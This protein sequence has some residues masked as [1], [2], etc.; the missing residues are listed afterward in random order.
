MIKDIDV[1]FREV[2]S[3]FREVFISVL[4]PAVVEQVVAGASTIPSPVLTELS[5]LMSWLVST[6]NETNV[7]ALFNS[8]NRDK[9]LDVLH[10]NAHISE[11]M[12]AAAFKFWLYMTKKKRAIAQLLD[13]A[14]ANTVV[15]NARHTHD[16]MAKDIHV[17]DLE[18]DGLYLFV[19][20]LVV[21]GINDAC[22]SAITDQVL[23]DQGVPR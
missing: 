14:N 17:D 4:A 22:I 3:V 15:G 23:P 20:L 19:V 13:T 5:T 16:L 10:E 1:D 7:S 8:K 18:K 6:T 9:L 11:P 2:E 12:Y 21:I